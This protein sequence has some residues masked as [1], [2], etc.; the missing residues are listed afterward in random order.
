MK[1]FI[2][3]LEKLLR[4]KDS[5]LEKEKGKL[6]EINA[7][8]NAVD[9]RIEDAR[10]QILALD[11]ERQEKARQGTTVNELRMYAFHIENTHRLVEQLK[12]ERVRISIEA[13]RQRR[14]VMQFSQEV[15]G[16]EKLREKQL[17][18]Y[19]HEAMHE[20]ELLVGE[21]V[22]SKYIQQQAV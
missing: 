19:N 22:A 5:L 18:E 13:E 8:L 12:R 10:N 17:E 9:Q 20:Q 6:A 1:K 3:S 11:L 15:S 4:Y 16:L 2:F 21:I 14:V 7:R